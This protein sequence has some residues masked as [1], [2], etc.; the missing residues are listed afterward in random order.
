MTP[1]SP[2]PPASPQSVPFRPQ[3]GRGIAVAVMSAVSLLGVGVVVLVVIMAQ[4]L[5]VPSLPDMPAA[6]GGGD[7]G[8]GGASASPEPSPV[9]ISTPT[10]DASEALVP[11][12]TAG[13]K[14]VAVE[15]HGVA[16]DVPE[17]WFAEPPSV[18]TGFTGDGDSDGVMMGGSAVYGARQGPCYSYP[19]DPGRSGIATVEGAADTAQTA[20]GTAKKWARLGYSNENGA[21]ELSAGPVVAFAANGLTGHQVTVKVQA[22]EYDCYPRQAVVRVVSFLSPAGGAVYNFIAFAD[23]SGPLA[24]DSG[25]LDTMAAS[26]RPMY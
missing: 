23:V 11:A 14:G 3:Q 6:G 26:L 21:A 15:E 24:P 8:D 25:V 18:V 20:L 9:A 17:T 7:D 5:S 2:E 22:P 16:Y 4:G 1:P 13:W 12:I 19:P 10:A